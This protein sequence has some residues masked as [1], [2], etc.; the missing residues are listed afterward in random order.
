MAQDLAAEVLQHETMM[1]CP[2]IPIIQ[3]GILICCILT[4]SPDVAALKSVRICFARNISVDLLCYSADKDADL[5]TRCANALDC[6]SLW[7]Q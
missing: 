6:L 2:T 7:T 4:C 1:E 5:N 3:A